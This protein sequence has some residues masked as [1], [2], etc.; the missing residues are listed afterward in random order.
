MTSFE[1]R[2]YPLALRELQQALD[3]PRRPLDDALRAQVQ[4]LRGRTYA[5]VGRYRVVLSP[6]DAQL[7]VDGVPTALPAGE[8]LLLGVGAHELIARAPEHRE[9]RRRIVVQGREDAALSFAL[10]PRQHEPSAPVAA[11]PAP[12]APVAAPAPAPPAADAGREGA[13]GGSRLWTWVAAGSAVALGAA[14]TGLWLASNSEYEDL[15]DECADRPAAD[16]CREGQLDT[17]GVTDLET[18]HHITLALAGA[19]GVAAVVLFFV[20]GQGDVVAERAPP[21]VS[22]TPL[23]ASVRGRF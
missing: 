14:S 4:A 2:N 13:T 16:P 23:G 17:S 9:L 15:E 18:G 8:K 21:A 20:E 11:T 1:L 5:Y 22:I 19:A 10:S 3:D 12:A 7:L 6:A